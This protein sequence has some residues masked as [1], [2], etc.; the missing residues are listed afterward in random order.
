VKRLFQRLARLLWLSLLAS[1]ALG[2]PGC[3]TNDPDNLS[4]R[5]W[6]APRGW[7]HGLPPELMEGR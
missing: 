2:L 6:N 1:V 4:S 7:E 5:P 3:A